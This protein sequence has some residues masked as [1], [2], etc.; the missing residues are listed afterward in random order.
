MAS[1]KKNYFRHSFGAHNDE[2]LVKII[3]KY[4]MAGY[5]YF[6]IIL[7]LCGEQA[8]ENVPEKFIFHQRTLLSNLLVRKDKLHSYLVTTTQLLL[9]NAT[10]DGTIIELCI[11]NLAKY[12]GKYSNKNTSNTPN[13]RKENKRKEK[14]I[15]TNDTDLKFDFEALYQEYPL[16]K[17]KK[18]GI[19]NCHKNIKTKE[20][21]NSLQ[22]AINNYC[23]QCST[24]GT[25]DQYIKHFSTFMNCW[26]DYLG[27]DPQENIKK[28]LK[29]L[30]ESEGHDE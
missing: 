28:L 12:L 29:Q 17:G 13:K 7:E 1:G 19:E 25:V 26:E 4:G 10:I 6:W 9:I 27:Y 8:S 24:D 30:D 15:K 16:K 18:K 11:P 2:K 20:R 23:S 3:E 21:Y 22:Q 5:A 14:E